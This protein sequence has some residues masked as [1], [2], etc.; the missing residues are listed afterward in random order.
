MDFWIFLYTPHALVLDL[1]VETISVADGGYVVACD[2][3]DC[4]NTEI[5]VVVACCAVLCC[6]IHGA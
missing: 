2:V 1:G 5:V 3:V 4:V 6:A